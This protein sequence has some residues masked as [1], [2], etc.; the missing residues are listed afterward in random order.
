MCVLLAAFLVCAAVS[1]VL[2]RGRA[3]GA[4][5]VYRDGELIYTINPNNGA[6]EYVVAGENGER[7]VISVNDNGKLKM[8]EANC[9]DG[10][11]MRHG[12][13]RSNDAIVCV[14]NRVVVEAIV[15]DEEIDAVVGKVS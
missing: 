2:L 10:T 4:V 15:K 1:I 11:C 8:S 9:H 6:A 14:P 5:G 13:L 12:V 7:N 3:E